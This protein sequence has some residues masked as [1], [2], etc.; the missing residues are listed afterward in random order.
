ML[1]ERTQ[2][3]IQRVPGNDVSFAFVKESTK[4]DQVLIRI[5]GI[6]IVAFYDRIMNLLFHPSWL[7]GWIFPLLPEWMP[8]YLF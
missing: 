1:D 5:G 3:T 6:F 8:T 7:H 2:E 4:R